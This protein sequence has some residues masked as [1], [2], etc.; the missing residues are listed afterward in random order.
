MKSFGL[1]LL[2][3]ALLVM[4]VSCG[5]DNESGKS[6]YSNPYY[7]NVYGNINS[8]YSYNGASL[9]QVMA[10]NPCVYG[11]GRVQVQIPLTSIPSTM[12]QNE[13]AVAVSYYGHV[14]A[15]VGRGTTQAPILVAY[16]CQTNG[17]Y[18]NGTPQVLDLAL[19]GSS[20]CAFRDLTR[21]TITVPGSPAPIY[22]G[23]MLGGT[24]QNRAFVSPVCF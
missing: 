14:A 19:G 15:L 3:L 11:G 8:P 23:T 24:S 13:I 22:L 16:L 2:T 5:K 6:S 12:Q 18:V 10:Q 1:H 21:L 7:N 9:N 17:S 20:R 4:L